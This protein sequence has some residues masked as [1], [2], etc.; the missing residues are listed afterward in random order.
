[1]GLFCPF[2]PLPDQTTMRTRCLGRFSV[3]NKTF[4]FSSKKKDFLLKNDQIWHF[5]SF[6]ARPCRL[7]RCPVGGSVGGCGL[8]LARHLF[9][10]FEVNIKHIILVR[11]S[12]AKGGGWRMGRGSMGGGARKTACPYTDYRD[13]TPSIA[14]L[15]PANQ[16]LSHSTFILRG[17]FIVP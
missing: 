1:M 2:R 9:T 17:V 12:K 5:W 13:H 11:V 16:L 3:G 4:D 15:Y 8:Y 7:I 6:W 14:L 10:L